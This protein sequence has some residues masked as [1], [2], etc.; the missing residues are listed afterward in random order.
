MALFV[1]EITCHIVALHCGTVPVALIAS[2]PPPICNMSPQ[3]RERRAWHDRHAVQVAEPPYK[4]A[5]GVEMHG[6][7]ELQATS[8]ELKEHMRPEISTAGPG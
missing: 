2:W 5:Q 8:S 7:Q 3:V 4:R 6:L 1:A